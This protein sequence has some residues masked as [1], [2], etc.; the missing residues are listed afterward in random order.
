MIGCV[1]VEKH[2]PLPVTL[3]S[4]RVGNEVVDVC[5]T[6]C[7]NVMELLTSF[8]LYN[9]PPPGRITKHYSKYVREICLRIWKD[10]R[11]TT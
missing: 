8:K 7:Y 2:V 6:T 4:L 1:C 9:G 11:P 5:P 3:K 10:S